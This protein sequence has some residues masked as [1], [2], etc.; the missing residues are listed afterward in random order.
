[1]LGQRSVKP[2]VSEGGSLR[3]GQTLAVEL[4][5]PAPGLADVES[6]S[7]SKAVRL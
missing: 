4:L 7:L 1:M 5:E 6:S 3:A 2:R